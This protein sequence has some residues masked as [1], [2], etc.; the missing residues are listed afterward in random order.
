MLTENYHI[1]LTADGRISMPGLNTRNVE[2][3]ADAI[4]TVVVGK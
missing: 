3:V 2:Y 1:Y 4:H